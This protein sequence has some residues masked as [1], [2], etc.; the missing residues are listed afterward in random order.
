MVPLW[1]WLETEDLTD[2]GAL[3]TVASL[4]LVI[5][6]LLR[7]LQGPLPKR[8]KRVYRSFLVLG[9]AGLISHWHFSYLTCILDLTSVLIAELSYVEVFRMNISSRFEFLMA[10]SYGAL[11]VAHPLPIYFVIVALHLRFLFYTVKLLPLIQGKLKLAALTTCGVLAL[12]CLLLS[13]N[14]PYYYVMWHCLGAVF[15]IGGA[16]GIELSQEHFKLD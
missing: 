1:N 5:S 3:G 4:C 6:G 16:F 10:I 2:L 9:V 15:C 14:S 12:V 13:Y 7:Y 11:L 8:M